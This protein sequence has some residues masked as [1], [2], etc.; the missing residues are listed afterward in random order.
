MQTVVVRNVKTN[1]LYEYLGDDKYKNLRTLGS[2][3]VPPEKAR[4]TFKINPSATE[5]CS[6]YPMVKEL[7]AKL[8]LKFEKK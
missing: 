6:E 1:D 7:I 5:I 4:E 2:G 8:D 3:L